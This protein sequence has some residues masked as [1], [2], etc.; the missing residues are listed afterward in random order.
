[1]EII[2][3]VYRELM[4]L[5]FISFFLVMTQQFGSIATVYLLPFEFGH[6]LIFG[7]AMAYVGNSI[8]ATYRQ[9]KATKVWDRIANTSV[10]DICERLEGELAAKK[11]K[12]DQANCSQPSR[13]LSPCALYH[14]VSWGPFHHIISIMQCTTPTFSRCWVA[15]RRRRMCCHSRVHPPFARVVA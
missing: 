10:Q 11:A 7:V 1:M 6:L 13:P 14:T 15:A 5:G 2:A 4:I 12:G 9:I 3:K 8:V